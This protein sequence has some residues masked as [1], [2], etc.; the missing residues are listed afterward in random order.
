MTMV[1]EISKVVIWLI[2]AGAIFRVCYCFF[3]LIMADEDSSM[4]KKRLKNTLIFYV[5][6]ESAFI[7]KNLVL[8]YYS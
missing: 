2:R 1:D 5:I 3:R 4:Y 8:S 6:A 7:V